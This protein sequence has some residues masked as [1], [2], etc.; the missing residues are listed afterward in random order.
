MQIKEDIPKESDQKE[1]W[2]IMRKI[3]VCLL[4]MLLIFASM[5][6]LAEE[7]EGGWQNILLMGGDQRDMGSENVGRTDSM[8]ILS[9]NCEEGLVKMTS[10][11]RDTWVKIPGHGNQKINAANVFGGPELAMQIVNENFGTDI[12]D[13]MLVNMEDLAQI[14]DLIGGVEVEVSEHEREVANEYISEYLNSFKNAQ[15]YT[16]DTYITETGFVRLNGLQAVG[17]CRDRYTGSDFDRVMRQ[18]KVMLAMAQEA[19]DMEIDALLDIAGQIAD[20]VSTNMETDELKSLATAFM[21]MEIEDVQQYR[22]PANGTYD[23]GI[24]NG[25]WA[26]RPNFEKNKTLLHDFIYGE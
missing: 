3:F 12:E 24:K 5:P 23:A 21:V 20:V 22:I 11:M 25:V 1:R 18:Q 17:Y 4:A 14:I 26:I 13:Y 9:I 15:E 8:I 7:M 16:G 2:I 19:Q 6:V 10:I